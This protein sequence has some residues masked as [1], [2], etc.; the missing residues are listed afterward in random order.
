MSA[1]LSFVFALA[2]FCAFVLLPMATLTLGRRGLREAQ[3]KQDEE[4]VRRKARGARPLVG[5]IE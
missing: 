1:T 3:Q 2:M 5:K 4:N